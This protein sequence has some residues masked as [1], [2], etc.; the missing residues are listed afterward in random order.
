M[1]RRYENMENRAPQVGDFVWCNFP[2]RE[3]PETPAGE[4][5]AAY[6]LG[7]KAGMAVA[8][9]YTTTTMQQSGQPK[10]PYKIS[11]PEESSKKMGMKR[12]F[13]IDASRIAFLPIDETFFPGSDSGKLPIIGQADNGLQRAIESR[14]EAAVNGSHLEISGPRRIRSQ[15]MR[16]FG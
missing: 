8:V 15:F 10:S 12:P 6:I 2:Y 3:H 14:V 1:N 16:P 9:V 7:T 13:T 4:M 11:I 5:H